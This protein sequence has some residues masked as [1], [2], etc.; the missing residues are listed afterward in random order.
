[1][2]MSVTSAAFLST[3]ASTI[4]RAITDASY[5]PRK[6]RSWRCCIVSII[7]FN[8]RTGVLLPRMVGLMAM[9][10][11]TTRHTAYDM[12]YTI[13]DVDGAI[14]FVGDGFFMLPLV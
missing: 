7:P 9:R 10:D 2:S 1:M 12:R 11:D 3:A 5:S 6:R 13:V 4:S 8:R 14:S